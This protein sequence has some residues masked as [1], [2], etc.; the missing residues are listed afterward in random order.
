MFEIPRL[1]AALPDVRSPV[2]NGPSCLTSTSWT[3]SLGIVPRGTL[4]PSS[5]LT[6]ISSMSPALRMSRFFRFWCHSLFPTIC[7]HRR[8]PYH[9]PTGAE[10]TS[11]SSDGSGPLR[12]TQCS[13]P[14]SVH[15]LFS[16]SF[17][18]PKLTRWKERRS[19]LALPFHLC[20]FGTSRALT[21]TVTWPNYQQKESIMYLPIKIFIGDK[22]QLA[23]TRASVNGAAWKV[24]FPFSVGHGASSLE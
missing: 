12:G 18:W 9:C 7:S 2:M 23:F 8:H 16:S 5:L 22:V 19:P 4:A 10:E 14:I 17:S 21:E 6:S 1:S 13:R 11:A 3:R 24:N 15:C 20:T